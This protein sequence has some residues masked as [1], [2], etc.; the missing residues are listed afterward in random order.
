MSKYLTG[1]V[2]TMNFET[3]KYRYIRI[4]KNIRDFI[5]VCIIFF[6][7]MLMFCE[8]ERV[9]ALVFSSDLIGVL[10]LFTGA[11]VG[12]A[13]GVFMT[14]KV[15]ESE[16]TE[17][18]YKEMHKPSKHH[19]DNRK[20]KP[21]AKNNNKP[22]TSNAVVSAS[23]V[24]PASTPNANASVTETTPNEKI[25]QMFSLLNELS[26]DI[27]TAQEKSLNEI[28]V[29]QAPAAEPESNEILQE[30]TSDENT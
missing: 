6:G 9:I 5:F 8:Y 11:I 28:P 15:F 19:K 27:V 22:N 12:F 20:R 16:E 30:N 18:V 13:F 17:N 10:G 1:E 3:K 23:N 21:N 4:L 2:T 29:E 7:L 26:S 24:E 25:Q 14:V